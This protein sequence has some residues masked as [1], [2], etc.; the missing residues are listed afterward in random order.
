[1]DVKPHVRRGRAA[2]EKRIQQV[3]T[4][5]LAKKQAA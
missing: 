2:R 3:R 1:M 4:R 5:Q